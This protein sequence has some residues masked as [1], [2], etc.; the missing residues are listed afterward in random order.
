M[1]KSLV[2]I[3]TI[4]GVIANGAVTTGWAILTLVSS[5]RTLSHAS[6][7]PANSRPVR[8]NKNIRKNAESMGTPAWLQNCLVQEQ[9]VS[10]WR[11]VGASLAHKG[12]ADVSLVS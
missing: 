11:S 7:K 4:S 10:K 5:D 3:I 8:Y 2:S 1:I 9:L 6:T 12:Q